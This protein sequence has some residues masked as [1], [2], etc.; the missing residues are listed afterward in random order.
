MPLSPL[1]LSYQVS[2]TNPSLIYNSSIT[3][4]SLLH[5]SSITPLSS[6]SIYHSSTTLHQSSITPPSSSSIYH[7]S[8]TLHHTSITSH[9]TSIISP[10]LFC[11]SLHIQNKYKT[12]TPTP[13]K[14]TVLKCCMTTSSLKDKVCLFII[15]TKGLECVYINKCTFHEH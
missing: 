2:T 5:Q 10:S 7:S 9:H 15:Q 8:T 3:R 1:Y 4:L 12:A 11:H 13:L 14:S 6:S